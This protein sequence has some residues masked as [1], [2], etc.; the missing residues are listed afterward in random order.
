MAD[1][2]A[3]V[4]GAGTAASAAAPAAADF[5]QDVTD[6]DIAR[7]QD[8]IKRAIEE[9]QPLVG[10]VES[11]DVLLDEY[12][13]NAALL[14]KIADF[15]SKYSGIRRSRGDGNCFYRSFLVCV[16]EHFVKAGVTPVPADAAAAAAMAA[17]ASQ[18][19]TQRK[20]ASLVVYIR[21]SLEKLIALGYPDITTPDFQEAMLAYM[22]SLAGPGATVEGVLEQFKDKMGS[23]YVIT[24]L[25]CL[26]SLEILTH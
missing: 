22:E 6:A 2:P 13:D 10:D 3:A 26:C 7:Q 19:A 4:G 21:E 5:R 16:G 18:T 17:D 12:K 9:S 23:F 20:Y 15:A 25:R 24:Y 14:P 11:P 1:A 8:E